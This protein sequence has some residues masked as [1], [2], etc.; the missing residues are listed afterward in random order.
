[1]LVLFYFVI[2][3]VVFWY[4]SKGSHSETS[5]YMFA[6]ICITIL[7]LLGK[8][9]YHLFFRPQT[10]LAEWLVSGFVIGAI[11]SG[12]LA[13]F[14]AFGFR[15]HEKSWFVGIVM[16][17]VLLSTGRGWEC[18]ERMNERRSKVRWRILGAHWIAAAGF[19]VLVVTFYVSVWGNPVLGPIGLAVFA[20]SIV[21]LYLV[22]RKCRK[23]EREHPEIGAAKDRI[24]KDESVFSLGGGNCLQFV[25]ICL[26]TPILF[27]L[28]PFLARKNRYPAR[29]K[30]EENDGTS[31]CPE[32]RDHL[33]SFDLPV[34][35]LGFKPLGYCT[36]EETSKGNSS[37]SRF[38]THPEHILAQCLV[39]RTQRNVIK[40][41]NLI[42]RTHFEC[43]V[44]AVTTSS[45]I[46]EHDDAFSKLRVMRVSEDTPISTLFDVHRANLKR[47][48]RDEVGM[49][50]PIGSLCDAAN[51]VREAYADHRRVQIEAGLLETASPDD[52]LRLTWRGALRYG[53]AALPPFRQI[54]EAR[55]L[56][57]MAAQLKALGFES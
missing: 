55:Q 21:P 19:A 35:A 20:L 31:L 49:R 16:A 45:P 34:E 15:S 11:T 1:M 39:I 37:V 41:R 42:F 2:M 8:V 44:R 22:E 54:R 57:Y 43:G 17:A 50:V 27:P 56:K 18:A 25:L 6:F 36:E 10:R 40:F 9:V 51:C 4:P 5:P 53:W 3:M 32:D 13:V 33:N 14:D 29:A 7:I 24:N 48:E 46:F 52:E 47:I 30:L 28:M 26:M 12:A 23:F 38:W